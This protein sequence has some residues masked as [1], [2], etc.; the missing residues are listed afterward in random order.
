MKSR[1]GI[2]YLTQSCFDAIRAKHQKW[3]KF[4]YCNTV[5]NFNRYKQARNTVTTELRK[6]KYNYEKDLSAKIKT[7]NKIFR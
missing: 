6:A 3:L 4:K 1:G 7:D 2:P 5:E